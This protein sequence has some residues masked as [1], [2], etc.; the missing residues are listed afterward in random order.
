MNIKILKYGSVHYLTPQERKEH[1]TYT[2]VVKDDYVCECELNS[3]GEHKP[4]T[5]LPPEELTITVPE[6]FLSDGATCSPDKGCSWVFH[7]WLYSTHCFDHNKPC[8]R[9]E[10]D[11]VMHTI[12][13]SEGR[14]LYAAI[15]RF[16]TKYNVFKCFSK[17]WESS[18]KRGPDYI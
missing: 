3:V 6:N 10:A 5:D 18:G 13:K 1:K 14:W 16:M 4:S 15:F 17:A 9:E 7:D 12:L 2:L 8:T 11:Q